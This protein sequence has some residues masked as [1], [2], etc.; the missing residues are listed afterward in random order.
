MVSLSQLG[1]PHPMLCV[2]P[3][4]TV[5][6]GRVFAAKQDCS[7]LC[8]IVGASLKWKAAG[9]WVHGCL[10][11]DRESSEERTWWPHLVCGVGPRIF[12]VKLVQKLSPE[13][14][15]KGSTS[16]GGNR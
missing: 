7:L 1:F 12:C 5:V 3:L 6:G 15:S 4:V 14:V 11:L 16:L 13:E 8:F 2:H 9:V 10:G